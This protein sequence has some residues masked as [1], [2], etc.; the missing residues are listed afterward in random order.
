VAGPGPFLRTGSSEPN[1]PDENFIAK[2]ITYNAFSHRSCGSAFEARLIFEGSHE[3]ASPL[4]NLDSG[5]KR[6]GFGRSSGI[7]PGEKA[8]HAR[9]DDRTD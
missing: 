9:P 1:D 7:A 8:R 5:L 6:L 4:S 3:A 2:G